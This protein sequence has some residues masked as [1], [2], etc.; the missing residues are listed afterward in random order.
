MLGAEGLL[1]IRSNEHSIRGRRSYRRA[2][3][4]RGGNGTR[5]FATPTVSGDGGKGA[6]VVPFPIENRTGT[7]CSGCPAARESV[8]LC[9]VSVFN[10]NTS[11]DD[12]ACGAGAV[13]IW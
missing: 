10:K 2:R 9:P 5:Y 7:H 8:Q 6:N 1:T 4:F 13:T 3:V 11:A 12:W